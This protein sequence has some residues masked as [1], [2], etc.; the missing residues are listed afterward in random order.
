M[1][2]RKYFPVGAALTSASSA[3]VAK[4]F[5]VDVIHTFVRQP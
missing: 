3:E 1:A 5:L 2:A 4:R